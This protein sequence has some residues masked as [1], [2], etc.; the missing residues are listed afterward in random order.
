VTL[1]TLREL[2]FES[3]DL[4]RQPVD[5]DDERAHHVAVRLLNKR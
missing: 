4:L 1:K 2:R 5:H 3:F